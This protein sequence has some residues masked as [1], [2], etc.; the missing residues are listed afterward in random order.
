MK[1]VVIS[2]KE[3]SK[4][5][6]DFTAVDKISFDVRKGEIFGF[7]GAN[8]AGKTTAMR[9]LCGL[10][11]PTH[12][13]GT[14]AGFDIR[15]QSEE[16]KRNIGYMSQKF[17]LYNN[18]TVWENIRL[19]AGIYGLSKQETKQRAENI[20]KQ[21]DFEKERNTLV[22]SLPLGW[23]QKLSFSIATIHKPEIVF[24]DEPTGGVDPITRRQFWEMIYQASNEGTTIFVT[25]HYMDEAEYC[26]RVSIMVDGKIEAL[27][28]PQA[29]KKQFGVVSMDE[30]FRTLARRAKRGD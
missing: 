26:S 30:V 21:L 23:K 19:F 18:L 24:L 29:L 11:F 9:M 28:T 27:D 12:G 13:S 14:V 17:S 16:I 20:F 3:I 4:V 7:L 2:V 25:T 22:A 8:G 15:K 1:E 10:S 6:G 5:F